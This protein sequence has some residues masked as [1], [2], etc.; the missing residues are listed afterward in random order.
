VTIKKQLCVGV[1]ECVYL[2]CAVLG[3]WE[4]GNDDKTLR[5]TWLRGTTSMLT[6]IQQ[7][8]ES[9]LR[10]LPYNLVCAVRPPPCDFFPALAHS[11]EFNHLPTH[12]FSEEPNVFWGAYTDFVHHL[13]HLTLLP[14]SLRSSVQP[15]NN[16][17][18]SVY[19]RKPPPQLAQSGR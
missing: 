15:T 13:R 19:K 18:R 8:S 4:G 5:F 16:T 6:N 2:C 3:D 10:P 9:S 11:S 12:H 17:T 14:G 7:L 1:P